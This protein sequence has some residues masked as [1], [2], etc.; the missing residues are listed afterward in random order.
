MKCGNLILAEKGSFFY[1]QQAINNEIKADFCQA[2]GQATGMGYVSDGFVYSCI[3]RLLKTYFAI[4]SF[5][6]LDIPWWCYAI[7][8]LLGV[9][10][11]RVWKKP[12]L[13]LLIGYTFLI[14]AETVLIRKP[15]S[16]GRNPQAR[17][18]VR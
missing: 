17:P 2:H 8:A 3:T 18:V 15:F 13:G 5:K 14:L 10:A 7:A 12:S 9:T 11:W 4:G 1:I 16:N 6:L